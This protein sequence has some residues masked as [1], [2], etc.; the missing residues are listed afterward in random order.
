MHS[1]ARFRIRLPKVAFEVIDGEVLV[2][3]METGHYYSLTGVSAD[4]WTA[5]D[6]GLTIGE[7]ITRVTDHWDGAGSEIEAAVRDFLGQLEREALIEADG[8]SRSAGAERT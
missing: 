3:N 1:T 6:A 2:I 4:I 7:T 5:I 8:A